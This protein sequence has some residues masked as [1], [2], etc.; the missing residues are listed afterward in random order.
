[1]KKL[2]SKLYMSNNQRSSSIRIIFINYQ[3]SKL[4]YNYQSYIQVRN[5]GDVQGFSSIAPIIL[6][7]DFS[8]E[9]LM[10]IRQEDSAIKNQVRQKYFYYG[11][12]DIQIVVL[13][14]WRHV[15]KRI[16]IMEDELLLW[17]LRRPYHHRNVFSKQIDLVY[18]SI[19][20]LGLSLQS[21][22][23][24]IQRICDSAQINNI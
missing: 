12:Q 11:R 13:L 10:R 21:S 23:E 18:D 20:L 5:I 6:S 22:I 3:T 24:F 19:S 1:M 17:M 8:S 9:T 16:A 2:I 4:Q 15:V 7:R 14:L